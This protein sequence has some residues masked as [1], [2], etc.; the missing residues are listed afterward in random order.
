MTPDEAHEAMKWKFLRITK[1]GIETVKSTADDS[2]TTT[3]A[4]Y[5]YDQIRIFFASEFGLIL[6][7]PNE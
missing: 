2:F 6:P 3:D 1:K 4:E 7:M 5:Y